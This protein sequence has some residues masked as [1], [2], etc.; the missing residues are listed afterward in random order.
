M[1]S[2][3]H[4]PRPPAADCPALSSP[5][6]LP[7]QDP[8]MPGDLQRMAAKSLYRLADSCQVTERPPIEEMAPPEPKGGTE[9]RVGMAGAG[10]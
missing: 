6:S 10:C 1:A 3:Y 8:H 9:V 5:L 7:L 4:K 2:A